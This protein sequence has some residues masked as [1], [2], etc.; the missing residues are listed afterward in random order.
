[1]ALTFAGD[2]HPS[3][4]LVYPGKV[5]GR[6]RTFEVKATTTNKATNITVRRRI[7]PTTYQG[8]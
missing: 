5:M 3:P 6:G 2:C 7:K 1:M 8:T 4:V